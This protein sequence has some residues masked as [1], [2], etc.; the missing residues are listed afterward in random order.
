MT[1]AI[2]R[3]QSMRG[4]SL[5]RSSGQWLA[6]ATLIVLAALPFVTSDFVTLDLLTR[7]AL[8]GI[9]AMGLNLVLGYARQYWL[10]QSGLF[11]V[12]AYVSALAVTKWGLPFWA[13]VPLATVA[14]AA[15]GV[16]IG[17]PGLRLRGFYLALATFYFAFIV[18]DV[19]SHF[20][21]LGGANG[22][23]GIPRLSVLGHKFQVKEM[24]GVAVFLLVITVLAIS[25]VMNSHW[26]RVFRFVGFHEEAASCAGMRV[27]N[28]RLLVYFLSALLVGLSGAMYAYVNRFVYPGSLGIDMMILILAAVVI[29]GLATQIGPVVGMAILLFLPQVTKDFDKYSLLIYGVLLILVM[30]IVPSGVVPASRQ[31]FERALGLARSAWRSRFGGGETA[32]SDG[33]ERTD[34]DQEALIANL[35][36]VRTVGIPNEPTANKPLLVVEHVSKNFG[37]LVALNDVSLELRPGTLTAII[38]PNG[39]GKT[40]LLNVISGLHKPNSGRVFAEGLPAGY[41]PHVL[42]RSGARRTF[43]TPVLLAS[44]PVMDNVLM[45]MG[46]PVTG[47]AVASL[48]PAAGA[49]ERESRQRA[50]EILAFLG[51]TGLENSAAGSLPAG[52]QRLIELARALLPGPRLLILDE[53]TV[54]LTSTETAAMGRVLKQLVDAGVAVLLVAHDMTFIMGHADSIV[55]LDHGEVVARGTPEDIQADERVVRS[56]IGDI[57]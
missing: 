35:G 15:T 3:L 6:I 34:G 39:S 13:G 55:V 40:T 30:A 25:N 9:A 41:A 32:T 42:A 49:W 17:L 45:G 48:W 20:T 10:G 53:P 47:L 38:G 1:R 31:L 24:Y 52:Q 33:E 57:G 51:L 5:P 11:A 36:F 50:R 16:I 27:W 18:P 56:Y 43:Q 2:A 7:I 4:M 44:L 23:V 21:Y 19:A 54:G 37:G 26:G 28:V 29:G 14:T 8:L 12:G 46:M 22:L